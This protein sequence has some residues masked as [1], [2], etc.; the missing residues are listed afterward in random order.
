MAIA[1][2]EVQLDC[3]LNAQNNKREQHRYGL[4]LL[5]RLGL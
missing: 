3:K 5:M 4:N 1:A 2:R